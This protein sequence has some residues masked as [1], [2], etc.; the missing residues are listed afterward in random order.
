MLVI[1]RLVACLHVRIVGSAFGRNRRKGKEEWTRQS[2]GIDHA[3]HAF[4]M[5][6]G[7]RVAVEENW[8]RVVDGEIPRF[9]LR[10]ALA[11]DSIS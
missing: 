6:G 3:D 2:Y 11:S 10:I 8:L 1:E 4:R 5:A 7:E 9:S